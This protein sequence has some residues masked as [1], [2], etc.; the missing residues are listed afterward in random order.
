MKGLW[1][2]R[3]FAKKYT[4]GIIIALVLMAIAGL[5]NAEALY[6]TLPVFNQLFEK[7]AGAE[8]AAQAARMQLL[9]HSTLVLFCYLVGAAIAAGGAMYMGEWLGQKVLIDLRAT[10]FEHL[11]MLSMRFF[12]QQRSERLPR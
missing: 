12:D 3:A 4:K 5:L 6:K 7:L 10:V 1:A 11:Q 2:L 8:P 9:L